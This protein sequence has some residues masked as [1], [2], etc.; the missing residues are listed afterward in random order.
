MVELYS[1]TNDRKCRPYL[2]IYLELVEIEMV[3]YVCRMD[4]AD[5]RDMREWFRVLPDRDFRI[6]FY[7]EEKAFKQQT[8][9][10]ERLARCFRKPV[11]ESIVFEGR[12]ADDEPLLNV[13]LR[14]R[15]MPNSQLQ[16]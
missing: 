15:A 7:S 10:I 1:L 9:L 13:L 16:M 5:A 11:V 2:P 4:A 14:L 3:V 6:Y 12:K 8:K